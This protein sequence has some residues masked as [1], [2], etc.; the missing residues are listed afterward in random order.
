[1]TASG[2]DDRDDRALALAVAGV[3]GAGVAH[4]LRNTLAAAESAI[5][6]AR[7][8]AADPTRL[9]R[10]LDRAEAEIRKSQDVIDRVLGLARG[11][12][13]RRELVSAQEIVAGALREL[14]ETRAQIEQAVTP[15]ELE[16]PCDPILLERVLVNL[17]RNAEEALAGRI[18]VRVFVAEGAVELDV[19]D[20]GPGLDPALAARVFEPLVTGKQTGS[21]LGLALCRAIVRAHGGTLEATRA[22]SG[23]ALFRVVLPL[24]G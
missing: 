1:V 20:D 5:F 24:G 6:L 21:G 19:S 10:H 17:L 9:Y 12:P 8:D 22:P 13:I 4:E 2:S 11:E 3:L 16:V 7:R 18:E 14:G 15:P 23:G